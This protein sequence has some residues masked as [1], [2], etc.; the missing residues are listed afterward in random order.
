MAARRL[1]DGV[2]VYN[3][4]S[5]M[6]IDENGRP[7]SFV[8]RG[9]PY[10]VTRVLEDWESMRPQRRKPFPGPLDHRVFHYRVRASSPRGQGVIEV[11]RQYKGWFVTAVYD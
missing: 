6:A 9:R 7:R 10:A 8:W 2:R 5:D 3:E 11:R 1:P 4:P